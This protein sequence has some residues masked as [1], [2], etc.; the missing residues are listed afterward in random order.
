MPSVKNAGVKPVIDHFR[1]ID[2]KSPAEIIIEQIKEL[3]SEGVLGP[4]DRLPSERAL[5]ERFGVGRGHIREAIK[6][7]EFYGILKTLPQSGTIVASLG[8]KA[9]EGLISNV[10]DLDRNDL[11][12][13]MEVRFILEL[14]AAKLAATRRSDAELAALKQ[15]HEDFRRQVER[16]SS[17]LEEDLLFHLKIAE[18]SRNSVLRSLIGL[19]TPDVVTLS[20]ERNTCRDGRSQAAVSEHALVLGAIAARDPN[21]AAEAMQTHM[22]RSIEQCA[23]ELPRLV[24]KRKRVAN[25]V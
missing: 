11:A 18:C 8:V 3:L 21:A 23:A 17:A 16:G 19:I 7:L 25:R 22:Q 10:L 6:R 12:S 4:G 13:L 1:E 14:H 15:S 2:V 20:R 5:A 24:E 9:L